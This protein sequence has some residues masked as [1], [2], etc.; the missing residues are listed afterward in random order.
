M[1]DVADAINVLKIPKVE[2]TRRVPWARKVHYWRGRKFVIA[3]CITLPQPPGS[4]PLQI[5]NRRQMV[6]VFGEPNAP[7]EERR[8]YEALVADAILAQSNVDRK[9]RLTV[10]RVEAHHVP[11]ATVPG[12]TRVLAEERYVSTEPRKPR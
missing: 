11:S 3:S 10:R 4:P 1:N 8:K 7:T 12:G 2:P 5:S 9:E 6:A